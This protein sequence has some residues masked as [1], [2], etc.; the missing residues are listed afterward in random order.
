MALEGSLSCLYLSFNTL[1]SV[2]ELHQELDVSAGVFLPSG[3]TTYVCLP[4]DYT[5]EIELPMFGAVSHGSF[6]L[7]P[8]F[9]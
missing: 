6:I 5:F 4:I 9:M 7:T 8:N 2:I 1:L 3:G